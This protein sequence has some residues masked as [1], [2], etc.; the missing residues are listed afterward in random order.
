[1]KLSLL[2][3]AV[4]ALAP[5]ALAAPATAAPQSA[6]AAAR[7][8]GTKAPRST[9]RTP[10][11]RNVA[12]TSPHRSPVTPQRGVV[13]GH[14]ARPPRGPLG[15][16]AAGEP[17]PVAGSAR[18]APPTRQLATNPA[19]L[20]ARPAAAST[21]ASPPARPV[22]STRNPIIGGPH[23]QAIG[24]VGGPALSRPI[25]S[26]TIDGTQLHRK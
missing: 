21:A 17:G 15:S 23:T 6:D 18:A 4:L 24:H 26:A 13:R 2:W 1:M 7:D 12:G 20:P 19:G 3:C 25:R 16:R 5:L 8:T 9:P 10:K 14:L 22:V 11:T